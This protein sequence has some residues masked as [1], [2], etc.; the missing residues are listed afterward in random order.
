MTL[1]R[2]A[3]RSLGS[4]TGFCQNLGHSDSHINGL[5]RSVYIGMP[6]DLIVSLAVARLWSF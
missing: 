5:G 4:A 6:L 2:T 3:S 1:L